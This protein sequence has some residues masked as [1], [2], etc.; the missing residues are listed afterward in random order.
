MLLNT[1]ECHGNSL[2]NYRTENKKTRGQSLLIWIYI[3]QIKNQQFTKYEP[4][5]SFSTYKIQS[6]T[7]NMDFTFIP[8]F[9]STGWV[10][11]EI[12]TS[13]FFEFL[14]HTR[15][16]I[17]PNIFSKPLFWTFHIILSVLTWKTRNFFFIKTKLHLWGS[18]KRDFGSFQVLGVHFLPFCEK[19]VSVHLLFYYIMF[20]FIE[21]YRELRLIR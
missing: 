8:N 5:P 9:N 20:S 6:D 12:R 4:S 15:T 16:H 10:V 17:H 3:I 19:R 13:E 2:S 11:P 14:I 21:K 1:P 18:K 7:H